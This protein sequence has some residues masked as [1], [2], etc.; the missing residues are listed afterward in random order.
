VCGV[1]SEPVVSVTGVGGANVEAV[2][3][4]A[5]TSSFISDATVADAVEALIGAALL[6]GGIDAA[7]RMMNFFEIPLDNV[8][9]WQTYA[10]L[11]GQAVRSF[12][13]ATTVDSD[14]IEENSKTPVAP[15]F[16]LGDL[17]AIIGYTFQDQNLA[18]QAFNHS[19][20]GITTIPNYNRLEYLGDAVLDFLIVK[21]LFSINQEMKSFDAFPRFVPTLAAL[22]PALRKKVDEAKLPMDP[23][24]FT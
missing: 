21:Y 8:T 2:K 19:S 14:G 4:V 16:A 23:G 24:I 15:S 6:H 17:E 10:P 1:D 7:L 12:L 18:K 22:P 9:C 5:G 11:L 3:A 13:P 20:S